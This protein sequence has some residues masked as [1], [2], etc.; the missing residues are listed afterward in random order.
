S[1]GALQPRTP[2]VKQ[3]SSLNLP[4]RWDYRHVPPHLAIISFYL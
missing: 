4:S 1:V 2:E 3:S